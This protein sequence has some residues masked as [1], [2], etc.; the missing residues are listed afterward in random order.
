M[1]Y[2]CWCS[3]LISTL[4][5]VTR[6][7]STTIPKC[8]AIME[9]V[10]HSL[11]ESIAVPQRVAAPQPLT[12]RRCCHA[13]A[14]LLSEPMR[15]PHTQRLHFSHLHAVSPLFNNVPLGW[16]WWQRDESATRLHTRLSLCT[17]ARGLCVRGGGVCR[18]CLW[19]WHPVIRHAPSDT[20][21][22]LNEDQLF[23]ISII[24][25]E[26]MKIYRGE[27][28]LLLFLVGVISR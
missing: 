2:R 7:M 28:I 1:E 19:V 3:S 10:G 22:G 15:V 16:P 18:V 17:R 23:E 24:K 4:L 26:I 11:R 21:Q 14:Q 13:H 5:T 12:R 25:T 20:R 9:V 8:E 27:I 6:M